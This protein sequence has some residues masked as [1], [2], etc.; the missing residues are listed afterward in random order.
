MTVLH[1]ILLNIINTFITLI[2]PITVVIIL[3][4]LTLKCITNLNSDSLHISMVDE[5]LIEGR[6]FFLP[7]NSSLLLRNLP[8]SHHHV[9]LH[10]QI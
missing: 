4:I 5:D 10:V 9:C 1:H 7:T 8:L 2:N 6:I 3:T